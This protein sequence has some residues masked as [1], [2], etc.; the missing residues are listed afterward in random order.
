MLVNETWLRMKDQAGVAELGKRSFL[1]IAALNIRRILVEHHR[2]RRTRRRDGGDPLP[3]FESAALEHGPGI[4]ILALHEALEH[5]ETIAE[6]SA[7]V[8]EL[9]FFGGMTEPEAADVLGVSLRTVSEDWR[10][11]RAWLAQ[12]LGGE[13]GQ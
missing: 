10:Y 9:R 13:A 5:L 7:R 4:D 11:A 3:L 12:R 6:R 1:A 2:A 8:V